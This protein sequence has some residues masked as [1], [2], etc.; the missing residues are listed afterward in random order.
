ME[1]V[2][3]QP[4]VNILAVP[5]FP[6]QPAYAEA[7][8]PYGGVP[9]GGAP[10]GSAP[11]QQQAAPD[12]KPLYHPQYPAQAPAAMPTSYAPATN[13]PYGAGGVAARP[14][15]P[16]A[17]VANPYPNAYQQIATPT[18]PLPTPVPAASTYNNPYATPTNRPI[19]KDDHI[20]NA[21]IV[22]I[23]AINPYSSK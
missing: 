11:M 21:V 12:V 10:Y 16:S 8:K 19:V 14:V 5:T 23:S 7:P 15:V 9:Y 3:E 18:P 2:G 6:A 20:N 1:A 13:T 22:P 4:V 17:P